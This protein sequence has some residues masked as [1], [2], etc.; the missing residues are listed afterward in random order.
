MELKSAVAH[1]MVGR[2]RGGAARPMYPESESLIAQRM[3]G[4]K[5]VRVQRAARGELP[6]LTRHLPGCGSPAART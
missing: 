5:R 4:L 6:T 3:I 2:A 1:P